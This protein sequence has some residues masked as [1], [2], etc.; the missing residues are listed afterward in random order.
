MVL[1]IGVALA[2]R[3]TAGSEEIGAETET[4]TTFYLPITESD[5]GLEGSRRWD[6]VKGALERRGVRRLCVG[7]KVQI[8]ILRRL[9]V[10]LSS[11]D[12]VDD[13]RLAAWVRW[14]GYENT[15]TKHWDVCVFVYVTLELLYLFSGT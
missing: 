5:D 1:G 4:S 8:C 13:S 7:A 3:H 12:G 14:S 6:A 11:P 15:R 9:G 10:E 2:G